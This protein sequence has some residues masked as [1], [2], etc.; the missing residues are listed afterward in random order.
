MN[1]LAYLP[2]AVNAALVPPAEADSNCI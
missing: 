1:G 2:D